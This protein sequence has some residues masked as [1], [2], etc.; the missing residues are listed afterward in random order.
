M[1]FPC[2]LGDKSQAATIEPTVTV[3]LKW[4]LGN[5]SSITIKPSQLYEVTGSDVTLQANTEYQVKIEGSNVILL[6]DG[7]KLEGLL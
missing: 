7:K 4:F 3:K 2:L 1:V 6:K 5:Q